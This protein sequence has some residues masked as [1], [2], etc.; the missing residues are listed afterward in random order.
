[1]IYTKQKTTTTICFLLQGN[2]TK[3]TKTNKGN[4]HEKNKQEK[5]TQTT[6][7]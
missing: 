3:P 4:T 2:K 5:K 7:S 1:M 6:T